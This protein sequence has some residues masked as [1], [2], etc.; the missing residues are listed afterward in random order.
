MRRLF[1]SILVMSFT[2]HLTA[3]M[4]PLSDHY[5]VNGLAINPAFAGCNDA[6]SAT[7]SYRDQWVGFKDSPKSYFLSV[8]TP[9]HNDRIGLGLLVENNSIG[10]FKETNILGNYAY[11]MELS[12][13]KLALGLG[14]GLKVLNV[15]WNELVASDA[16]DAQLVNNATTSVLP[17][18]SL[19]AYYYTKKYY[20][21]LSMPL[22]LGYKLDTST[23][24]YKI[25]NNFSGTN[26][27]F[28]AGYEAGISPQIKF[29]P[30]LLIKYHSNNTVQIDYSAQINLKDKIWMGVG[31]RNKN[32]LIGMLQCQLNYQI[33]M[34]YSYDYEFGTIGKYVNGT[35]EIVLNYV[36]KFARK[37][38][39]PRQF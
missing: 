37:V 24:K 11:R 34:G 28:S 1:L 22:F 14:F 21:G 10:I 12:H 2:L 35:H 6:L 19:G 9:V 33:R 31:Y 18:F 7:I 23:G 13:G 20:I 27:F 17:A 8:H 3:Q 5:V 32:I 4:F 25:D 15:A 38:M 29:L 36:F 26:Y 39:G 30:S 16:N